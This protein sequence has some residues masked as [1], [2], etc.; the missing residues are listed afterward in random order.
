MKNEEEQQKIRK[1]WCERL[2]LYN[3]TPSSGSG[4][5]ISKKLEVYFSKIIPRPKINDLLIL[6]N[7][8]F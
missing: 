5:I 3:Y 6:S 4:G 2:L 1:N 8:K 7:S